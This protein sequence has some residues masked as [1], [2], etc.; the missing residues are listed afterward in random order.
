M[1][2]Q[3]RLKNRDRSFFR[4]RTRFFFGQ[5]WILTY[6]LIKMTIFVGESEEKGSKRPIDVKLLNKGQ[7]YDPFYPIFQQF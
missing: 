4:I 6:F 3:N 7:N 1:K 5:K 2:L